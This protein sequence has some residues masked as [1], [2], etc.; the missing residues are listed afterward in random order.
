MSNYMFMALN[1]QQKPINF[2]SIIPFNH[3]PLVGESEKAS[4]AQLDPEGGI[5]NFRGIMDMKKRSH[6]I[7]SPHHHD[8]TNQPQNKAYQSSSSSKQNPYSTNLLIYYSTNRDKAY[9]ASTSSNQELR[10]KN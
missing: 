4:A 10:T 8:S 1:H 9:Q 2:N 5:N 6:D 3:S 7:T